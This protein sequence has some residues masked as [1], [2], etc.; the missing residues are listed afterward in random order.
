MSRFKWRACLIS[1]KE[2]FLA[3]RVVTDEVLSLS[4]ST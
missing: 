3:L 1:Q 4:L 2:L